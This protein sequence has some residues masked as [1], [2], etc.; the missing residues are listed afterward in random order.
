MKIDVCKTP[1]SHTKPQVNVRINISKRQLW[2]QKWSQHLKDVPT[3]VQWH[4]TH[5]CLLKNSVQENHSVNL[6]RYWMSNISLLFRGL[7]QLRES[8]RQLKNSMLCS[9]TLK[10]AV[11][12][13]KNQK[14]REA[15]YHW[16]LHHPTVVKSPI[17]NNFF[18][19]LLMETPKKNA[20]VVI[21][22]FCT[23]TT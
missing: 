19:S 8:V 17:A 2:K 21:E 15:L 12:I 3:T 6:Q 14:V 1:I 16:I 7:V 13:K 10:S 11:V 23:R 18:M 20:K 4:I 22:S 9:H 5:V